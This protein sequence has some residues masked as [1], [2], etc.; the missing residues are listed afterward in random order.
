METVN[1]YVSA[2]SNVIWGENGSPQAQQ[3]GEEPISRRCESDIED[4]KTV[5]EVYWT[6]EDNNNKVRYCV[7]V[8]NKA[9]SAC[10]FLNLD[11]SR[12]PTNSIRSPLKFRAI[13]TLNSWELWTSQDLRTHRLKLP[14]SIRQWCWAM[15]AC[16]RISHDRYCLTSY[17]DIG[18]EDRRSLD[19]I[20]QFISLDY[21]VQYVSGAGPW[22]LA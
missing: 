2:A 3:H 15:V 19:S 7:F 17:Y 10:G 18:P 11:L 16:I 14:C 21:H 5:D 6:R 22:W 12:A 13:Q 20:V 4:N 8:L 9:A 1:R